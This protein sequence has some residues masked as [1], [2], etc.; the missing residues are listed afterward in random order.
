MAVGIETEEK[1]N[2]GI[3]LHVDR[4]VLRD[5]IEARIACDKRRS[6]Y[7]IGS[8]FSGMGF[9]LVALGSTNYTAASIFVMLGLCYY[10]CISGVSVN[11]V[12]EDEGVEDGAEKFE[13]L[14]REE[15]V[16]LVRTLMEELGGFHLSA[17]DVE[18]L[19][20]P[21]DE[22]SE[23]DEDEDECLDS[24]LHVEEPVPVVEPVAEA[25]E[26][27]RLARAE[28]SYS[29][30]IMAEVVE[31]PMDQPGPESRV[32][33]ATE[34]SPVQEAEGKNNVEEESGSATPEASGASD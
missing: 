26:P 30:G 13:E 10:M 25:A 14:D 22:F 34:P 15:K 3:R 2:Q 16:E 18:R 21:V 32:E 7:T 29:E 27:P 28:T 33:S 5:I 23:Q 20:Q 12:D 17:E 31:P 19:V 9:T 11:Y 1:E 8:V 4:G 6:Y 24:E